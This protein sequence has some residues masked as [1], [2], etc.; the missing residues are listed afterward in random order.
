V[1]IVVFGAGAIGGLFGALLAR[2]HHEVLLVARA[3]EVVAIRLHGLRLEGAVDAV[4]EVPAVEELTDGMEVE[5]VIVTV[6]AHDLA[7]AGTEIGRRLRPLPPLLVV[8]NGLE[9]EL[10]LIRGLEAGGAEVLPGA[11][12]RAVLSVPATRIGPGHLRQAGEGEVLLDTPDVPGARRSVEMFRELLR[13]AGLSVRQVPEIGREVWRKLIVNAAIN[14]VT[15]DHGV[16]NGH[17]ARDPWR[18]QAEELLREARSVATAE[19]F[20]FGDDELEADLWRVVRATAAN[21][22]SMLQDLE[23]G[24]RTEI[25]AISGELLRRG[26]RHGLELPATRRAYDRIRARHPDRADPR[27][28]GAAQSS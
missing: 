13:S 5:A 3:P 27:P 14:P 11:V 2:A 1:R 10:E 22:S 15:A 6:K 26:A 18:R 12:T 9:V 23:R 24:R 16:P 21:R 17:L 19:G 28:R 4:V 25:E 8:Q 20:V 7:P